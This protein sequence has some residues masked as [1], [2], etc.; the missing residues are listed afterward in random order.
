M[1]CLS[2]LVDCTS[3]NGETSLYVAEAAEDVEYRLREFLM[4]AWSQRSNWWRRWGWWRRI[5]M[6]HTMSSQ[7]NQSK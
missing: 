7:C 4:C 3:W 5:C 1:G 2:P 6:W